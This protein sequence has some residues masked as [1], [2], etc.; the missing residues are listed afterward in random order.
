MPEHFKKNKKKRK[1]S[2]W[3]PGHLSDKQ[4]FSVWEAYIPTLDEEEPMDTEESNYTSELFTD[5]AV[6]IVLSKPWT[7]NHKQIPP[8]HSQ[9]ESFALNPQCSVDLKQTY[10]HPEWHVEN[11]GGHYIDKDTTINIREKKN[12]LYESYTSKRILDQFG[13]LTKMHILSE[14]W[15]AFLNEGSELKSGSEIE[16][17]VDSYN[18]WSI[19]SD[20]TFQDELYAT[21]NVHTHPVIQMS[22]ENPAQLVTFLEWIAENPHRIVKLQSWISAN[23]MTITSFQQWAMPNADQI[24]LYCLWKLQNTKF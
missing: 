1:V 7:Q 23:Q 17:H 21:T 3:I 11:P 5:D 24:A 4:Y 9:L 22:P 14:L 10:R 15:I 2:F 6:S 19:R 8:Y 12:H 18:L 13:N 16:H 20:Q